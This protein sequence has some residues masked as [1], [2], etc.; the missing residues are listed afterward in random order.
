MYGMA[1]IPHSLL[2]NIRIANVVG[3]KVVLAPVAGADVA[4]A[5][6]RARLLSWLQALH[7][8]QDLRG[9]IRQGR[10]VAHANS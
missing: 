5:V 3:T 8:G 6:C 9:A 7:G 1:F 2:T 4:I 10:K